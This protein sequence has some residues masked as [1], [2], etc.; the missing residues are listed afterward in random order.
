MATTGRNHYS[1]TPIKDF[2]L[3]LAVLPTAADIARG[4]QL[5]AYTVNPRHQY[6]P[7][8]LSYD[9]YGNSTYWWVIVMLN[10]DKLKDPVR[11]LKAGLV[12]RIVPPTA[13]S[14]VV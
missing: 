5:E 10:R 11:D 8:L 2:Y 3:D 13:I 14:G 1:R 12:L 9:L 6:R 7:D 4:Q